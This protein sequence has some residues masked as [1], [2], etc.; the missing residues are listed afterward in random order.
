MLCF[1]K[2]KT[3]LDCFSGGYK[4]ILEMGKS[5]NIKLNLS[6]LMLVKQSRLFSLPQCILDE[7]CPQVFF[8]VYLFDLVCLSHTLI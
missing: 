3:C 2:N 5:I 7:E 6:I 4:N 1:E 8:P